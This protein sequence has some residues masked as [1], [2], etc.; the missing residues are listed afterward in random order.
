MTIENQIVAVRVVIIV[1]IK[2]VNLVI[3]NVESVVDQLL[4]VHIVLTLLETSLIL[5]TVN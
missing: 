1:L 4:I 3:I 5:V 2:A